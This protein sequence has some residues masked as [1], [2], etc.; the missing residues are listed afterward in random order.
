MSSTHDTGT[1]QALLKSVNSPPFYKTNNWSN[2]KSQLFRYTAKIIQN[3]WET[4]VVRTYL[5]S[6]QHTNYS[7]RTVEVGP[8]SYQLRSSGETVRYIPTSS[9]ELPLM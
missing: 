6:K 3:V 4:D 7:F 5:Q 8:G 2:Y 1:R 9:N